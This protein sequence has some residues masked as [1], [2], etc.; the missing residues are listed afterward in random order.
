MILWGNMRF[1]GT[2]GRISWESLENI[3]GCFFGIELEHH[4]HEV[5]VF[6]KDCQDFM[7]I[8]EDSTDSVAI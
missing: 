6:S 4:G 8:D 3:M 1:H 7:G 2:Q 5:W